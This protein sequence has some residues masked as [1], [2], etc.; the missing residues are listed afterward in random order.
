MPD[1]VSQ[2]LTELLRKREECFVTVWECEQKLQA[3]LPGF[4]IPPPPDLPSRQKRIRQ[5][6]AKN[7]P[8]KGA[9]AACALVPAKIR[10]LQNDRENAYRLV[11]KYEGKEQSSFQTEA[12][13]AN[14]LAGTCTED[15]QLLAIETV[16]FS[17][18]DNW[19][20]VDTI[21]TNARK[22]NIEIDKKPKPT[23]DDNE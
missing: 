22:G 4:P 14:A 16:L 1:S 6:T 15:F 8:D 2:K 7:A 18:P 19:S 21:W 13:L 5:Q 9:E 3:I 23:V 20:K 10:E 12:T 17:A 11:Y